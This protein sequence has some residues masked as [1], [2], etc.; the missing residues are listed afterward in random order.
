MSRL[1]HFTI[2]DP[3]APTHILIIPTKHLS[4]L[5]DVQEE[6]ERLL[7]KMITAARELAVRRV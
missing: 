7:G 1:W 5:R 4:S 6:D 2:S 3:V